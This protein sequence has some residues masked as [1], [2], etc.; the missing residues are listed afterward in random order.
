[1]SCV[2]VSVCCFCSLE[3]GLVGELGVGGFGKVGGGRVIT[4][5]EGC[6]GRWLTLVSGFDAWE[7]IV[8]ICSI[9]VLAFREY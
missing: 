9:Y 4:F 3:G 6:N 2:C 5:S 1:M 7:Y 8:C